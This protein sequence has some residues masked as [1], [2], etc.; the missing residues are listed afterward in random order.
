MDSRNWHSEALV[1]TVDEVSSSNRIVK[2]LLN[3]KNGTSLLDAVVFGGARSRLSS[4]VM[5]YYTGTMWFYTNPVKNA[6]KVQDFAVSKMRFGIRETLARIW[7]ASFAGE[8][9]IKMNPS[10]EWNLINSFLNGI[11]SSDNKE[12]ILAVLRFIWRVAIS[13]GLAPSFSH[14]A[15]CKKPIENVVYFDHSL[16]EFFCEN[17]CEHKSSSSLLSSQACEYLRKVQ[18]EPPKEASVMRISRK[19]VELLSTFLHR[20]ALDMAGCELYTVSPKN[21]IYMATCR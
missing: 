3:S 14:C 11:S 13:S 1:L 2:V 12:C 19:T 5:P 16:G 21:P 18:Y 9:C 17:C 15:H 10:I 20:F 4:L 6:H 7:A 8:L